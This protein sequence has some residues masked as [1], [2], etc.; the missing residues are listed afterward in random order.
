M[1]TIDS[2]IDDKSV[3]YQKKLNNDQSAS[4][5]LSADNSMIALLANSNSR[6]N[7]IGAKGGASPV[8]LLQPGEAVGPKDTRLEEALRRENQRDTAIS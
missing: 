1:H 7:V 4:H 3:G 8:N 2:R 5:G 6:E